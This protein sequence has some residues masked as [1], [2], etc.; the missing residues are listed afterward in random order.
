MDVGLFVHRGTYAKI[1]AAS[2][3]RTEDF[4]LSL[5]GNAEGEAPTPLPFQGIAD[6]G[7]CGKAPAVPEN[8]LPSPEP[9]HLERLT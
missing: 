6:P 1:G 2:R 5:P 3:I 9:T 8:R 4:R 7:A